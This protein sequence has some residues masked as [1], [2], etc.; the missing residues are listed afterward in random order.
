MDSLVSFPKPNLAKLLKGCGIDE[1][2]DADSLSTYDSF[3]LIDEDPRRKKNS[4]E[5]RNF[6]G[7]RNNAP[8]YDSSMSRE[9]RRR[10]SINRNDQFTANNNS[11]PTYPSYNGSVTSKDPRTR[12]SANGSNQFATNG[13]NAP[14]YSNYNGSVTGADP[15]NRSSTNGSRTFTANNNIVPTY[16]NYNDSVTSAD[17]RNR[18][19]TVESSNFGVN[20][21]N[22]PVYAKFDG[23]KMSSQDTKSRRST[24]ESEN[25]DVN[26]NNVPTQYNYDGS[27]M[28]S[29][30]STKSSSSD[31]STDFDEDKNTFPARDSHFVKKDY[32]NK[33]N[34][35]ENSNFNVNKNKDSGSICASK[36]GSKITATTRSTSDSTGPATSSNESTRENPVTTNPTASPTKVIV[37]KR[38]HIQVLVDLGDQYFMSSEFDNALEMY[39]QIIGI[40]NEVKDS[41]EN[42]PIEGDVH[43]KISSIILGQG[44]KKDETETFLSKSLNHLTKARDVYKG[45]L[46]ENKSKNEMET[47]ASKILSLK[48]VEVSYGIV[49]IYLEQKDLGKTLETHQ[50][51]VKICKTFPVPRDKLTTALLNYGNFLSVYQHNYDSALERFKEILEIQ[52]QSSGGQMNPSSAST[53]NSMGK[54]FMHRSNACNTSE[55]IQDAKRAE[56]CF[57]QA[58]QSFRLSMVSSGNERV[59]D[60]LY[61][62]NEA[63]ERQTQTKGILRSVSFAHQPEP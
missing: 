45:C 14:T 17:P 23:S 63:R 41:E 4:L 28:S 10:G 61:N 20:R 25:F 52:L 54:I 22:A 51:T 6:N 16:P 5:R 40:L 48:L 2:S 47:Q 13:N 36:G 39:I 49:N 43:A 46:E 55:G 60:T 32:T 12:R 33:R 35:I 3:S 1:I 59:I 9:P 34:T 31:A 24:V 44:E 30:D 53:L 58:M 42:D 15:R 57:L 50:D 8:T 11:T 37:D 21:N 62:L 56:S 29:Q 19:S 26:K 27:L 38:R 7:Q 18:S